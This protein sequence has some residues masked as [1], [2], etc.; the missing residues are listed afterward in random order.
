MALYLV[1]EPTIFWINLAIYGPFEEHKPKDLKLP[2]WAVPIH[3]VI[4]LLLGTVLTLYLEEPVRKRLK[5]WVH[6]GQTTHV[7]MN[8]TTT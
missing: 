7:T 6:G 2:L 8:P 4:S 3:L 1:H 5:N